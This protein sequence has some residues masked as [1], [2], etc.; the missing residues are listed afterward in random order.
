MLYIN[1]KSCSYAMI[2]LKIQT[3]GL[4]D[5]PHVIMDYK[6]DTQKRPSSL[7]CNYN[8]DKMLPSSTPFCHVKR[9]L[10]NYQFGAKEG[11]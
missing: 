7:Q 6:N 3:D 5:L 2:V 9:V 4:G 11:I 10:I 8:V 1:Q